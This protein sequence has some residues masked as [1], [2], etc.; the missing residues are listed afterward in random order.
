MPL[1]S[2]RAER[3]EE[4]TRSDELE[5]VLARLRVE[6]REVLYLAVAERYRAAEIA[7]M[8]GRPRNTV[9]SLMHR[10]KRKLRELLLAERDEEAAP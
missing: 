9:L 2:L 8:T 5:R 4:L 6:E 1:L 3:F 7:A 10:A